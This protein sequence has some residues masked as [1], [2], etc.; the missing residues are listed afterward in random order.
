MPYIKLEN[1]VNMKSTLLTGVRRYSSFRLQGPRMI[2]MPKNTEGKQTQVNNSDVNEELE[3]MLRRR[4]QVAYTNSLK[5]KNSFLLLQYNGPEDKRKYDTMKAVRELKKDYRESKFFPPLTFQENEFNSCFQK[6]VIQGQPDSE[7]FACLLDIKNANG[8]DTLLRRVTDVNCFAK[9]IGVKINN[10]RG[11]ISLQMLKPFLDE[12]STKYTSYDYES[13][14]KIAKIEQ[15][16]RNVH[17][18]KLLSI[19]GKYGT[20]HPTIIEDQS[21]AESRWLILSK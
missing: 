8:L 6:P 10:K 14:L 12:L 5:E 17:M 3:G 19:F 11:L 4:L 13:L 2:C 21:T 20:V 7:H 18:Y 15:L 1:R 16:P 9:V